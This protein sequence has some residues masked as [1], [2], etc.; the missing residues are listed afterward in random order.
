MKV[1]LVTS[2]VTYMP[3]NYAN[4][5]ETL[6]EQVGDH[7]AGLVVLKEFSWSLIKR[8]AGLYSISCTRLAGTLTRNMLGLLLEH[9]DKLFRKK[10]LPVKHADTIN[11]PEMCEWVREQHIDLII[12]LRT[13]CIYKKPILEAPRL[14]CINVHHGLLPEYRGTLCDLYALNE[15]RPTGFTIHQMNVRVDAGR[16]LVKEIVSEPGEKDYLT[17]LSRTGKAEGEALARLIHRIAEQDILPIGEPNICEDPVFTS[18]PSSEELK[19]LRAQGM[20]L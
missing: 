7:I 14:G 6:L 4:V 19:A 13:R 11:S 12:N 3:R 8:T 10:H 16:I 2:D 20:I 18:T 17:Y 9:R 15:N 5:F 1:L